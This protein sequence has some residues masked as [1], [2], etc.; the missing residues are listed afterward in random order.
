MPVGTW[1]IQL[2]QLPEGIQLKTPV[3]APPSVERILPAPPSATGKIYVTALVVEFEDLIVVEFA[4][5][6]PKTNEPWVVEALPKVR[7]PLLS[8][9]VLMFVPSETVRATPLPAW[10]ITKAVPE[11]EA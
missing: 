11:A 7:L 6:L 3:A 1:T 8:N 9:E 4:E 5:V 10:E 2:V